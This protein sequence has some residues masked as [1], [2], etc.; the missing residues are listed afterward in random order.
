MMG[1]G[2][3][4]KPVR[5]TPKFQQVIWL[6]G[7]TYKWIIE[8]ATEKGLAPNIVISQLVR[9]IYEAQRNGKT[10][11]IMTLEKPYGGYKCPFCSAIFSGSSDLLEHLA[12]NHNKD[13]KKLVGD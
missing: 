2:V 7:E 12:R 3:D 4:V 13:L 11:P 1:I 5:K 9:G 8:L 6:D 10:T